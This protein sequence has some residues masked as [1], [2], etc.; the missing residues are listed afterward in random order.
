MGKYEGKYHKNTYIS[1]EQSWQP[2]DSGRQTSGP[3]CA[4]DVVQCRPATCETADNWT[5]VFLS[6]K[7]EN[8]FWTCLGSEVSFAPPL[9]THCFNRSESGDLYGHLCSDEAPSVV[10]SSSELAVK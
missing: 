1:G 7:K 9:Q 5:S 6:R 4:T 2:C 10:V 3:D 8:E